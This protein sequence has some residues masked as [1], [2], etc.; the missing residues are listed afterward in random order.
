MTAEALSL[1]AWAAMF[2]L[3]AFGWY[4][5]F[6]SRPIFALVSAVL[7]LALVWADL[8]LPC[9]K[10]PSCRAPHVEWFFIHGPMLISSIAL[11]LFGFI[12][13]VSRKR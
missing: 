1:A 8:S 3:S 11:L 4:A 2:G 13:Y 6:T 7:A 10:D 9:P 5:L 12:R